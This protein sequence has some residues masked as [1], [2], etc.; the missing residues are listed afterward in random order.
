MNKRIVVTSNCVNSNAVD[1]PEIFTADLSREDRERIINLSERVKDLGVYAVEDFCDTGVWSDKWLDP[2]EFGEEDENID[3]V[4][5][6]LEHQAAR[7]DSKMI[8][9]TS[10]RIYFKSVPKHCNSDMALSTVGIQIDELRSDK[11]FVRIE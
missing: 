2:S 5:F 11:T 8:R 6:E 10:E 9:V 4:I 1:Y 3:E 7:V